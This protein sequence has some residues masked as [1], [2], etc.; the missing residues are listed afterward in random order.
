ML[1]KRR[2]SPS[3]KKRQTCFWFAVLQTE[4]LGIVGL[5]RHDLLHAAEIMDP[6]REEF[7]L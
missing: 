2:R 6:V 5:H 7:T 1:Q 4:D 3:S